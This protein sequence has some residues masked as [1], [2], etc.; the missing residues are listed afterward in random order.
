VPPRHGASKRRGRPRRTEQST[1]SG[2]RRIATSYHSRRGLATDPRTSPRSPPRDGLT[3]GPRSAQPARPP[4]GLPWAGP[5]SASTRRR[6][7]SPYSS[8]TSASY[9][10]GSR[11]VRPTHP[12]GTGIRWPRPGARVMVRDPSANGDRHETHVV[13][14]L[15]GCRPSLCPPTANS[16]SWHVLS[17]PLCGRALRPALNLASAHGETGSG[18]RDDSGN[19]DP[20]RFNRLPGPAR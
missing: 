1:S 16:R 6:T 13:R 12:T 19:W 4:E 14:H 20:A 3:P 9:R 7:T 15:S 5:C 8:L 2:T 11:C 17:G 10:S 18:N